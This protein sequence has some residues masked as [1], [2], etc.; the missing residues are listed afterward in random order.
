MERRQRESFLARQALAC[1]AKNSAEHHD[2]KTRREILRHARALRGRLKMTDAG[3]GLVL[4]EAENLVVNAGLTALANLLG[5]TTAGEF[6]AVVGFGSGSTTP[7]LT[8]SALSATPAYYNA[9]G[10]ITIGPTGGVA[11]GSVQFAYSLSSTDYAANPLTITELG[12]FGNTGGSSY[13]AA[14]GSSNPSW[15]VSH[16]YSAGNLIAD[17]NGNIQRCTTA[18][19]SGGS[20]PSWATTI[21]N[22]TSDASPLV[23]TLVALHTAPTPMIAHVVVPSFPYTGGGNYSGTWTI[24]M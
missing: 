22:T 24:S 3:S 10:T 9:V 8:D 7:A 15:A 16:A 14:V 11:S 19:T 21:G 23:W 17:S 20:H 6:V 4:F 1:R 18:G 13:P 5:G 12:L 2:A